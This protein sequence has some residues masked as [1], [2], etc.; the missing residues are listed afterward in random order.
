[1]PFALRVVAASPVLA[2]VRGVGWELVSVAVAPVAN[3]EGAPHFAI[4]YT[5][6]RPK[7]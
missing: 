5:F 3:L 1:M 6:K 4:L 7:G 2:R